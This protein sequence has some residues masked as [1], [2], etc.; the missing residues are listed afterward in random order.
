[1]PAPSLPIK[2]FVSPT[3]RSGTPSSE[4]A[5]SRGRGQTGLCDDTSTLPRDPQQ[6][7]A[8]S[9]PVSA[10]RTNRGSTSFGFSPTNTTS[11]SRPSSRGTT[12]SI[13]TGSVR[14]VSS[15]AT[16][17]PSG[18]PRNTSNDPSHSSS[19]NSR[20]SKSKTA[21]SAFAAAAA[22]TAQTVSGLLSRTTPNSAAV[23]SPFIGRNSGGNT[24][25]GG[26][27][28]RSIRSF[29]FNGMK[30]TSKNFDGVD[31]SDSSSI[32][33]G[34]N[35]SNNNGNVPSGASTSSLN[36]LSTKVSSVTQRTEMAL[37][38]HQLRMEKIRSSQSVEPPKEVDMK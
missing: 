9:R 2:S 33:S 16:A 35:M 26:S 37:K 13:S 25:V 34:S 8:H 10:T 19:T 7:Q 6:P 23:P 27:G 3:R 32:Y 14:S 36:S 15:F 21:S 30:R 24:G 20:S 28:A 5:G 17:P 11:S 22:F 1:M 18:I 38:K 31:E 29:S 4:R 12:R